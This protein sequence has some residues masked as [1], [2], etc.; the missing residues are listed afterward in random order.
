MLAGHAASLDNTGCNWAYQILPPD[1]PLFPAIPPG[2]PQSEALSGVNV[3]RGNTDYNSPVD[4]RAEMDNMDMSFTVD[5]NLGNYTLSS[6][7]A[8]QEEERLN[9]QDITATAVYFFDVLTQGNAPH[10]GNDQQVETEPSSFTQ[11][12]KIASPAEDPVNFVAGLFYSD[13]TVDAH[14]V[15]DFV[16]NGIDFNRTSETRH[17]AAYGRISRSL[18]HSTK[19]IAGLRYNRD[20]INYTAVQGEILPYIDYYSPP[21]AKNISTTWTGDITIQHDPNEHSMLYATYA[22]GYKPK[23]YNTAETLKPDAPLPA[24]VDR[25][26][27]DHFELGAKTALFDGKIVANTS[28]FDTVYKDYQVLVWTSE[29]R[30]EQGIFVPVLK[31]QNAGEAETRGVELDVS[32]APTYD[33]KLNLN[34]AYI[35]AQF[36]EFENA[37]AYPT[38]TEAEG[39]S[40]V[41]NSAPPAYIQDLSGKSMPD[42]PRFK[43][44]VRLEQR[45]PQYTLP[46]DIIIGGNYVYRSETNLLVNQNPGAKQDA[47]GILDLSVKFVSLTGKSSLT[48]FVNNVFDKFY[49]INAG[50]FWS[51]LWGPGNNVIAGDPARDALRYAG[52]ALNLSF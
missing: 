12:L 35:E 37:P 32:A 13:V 46:F 41:P 47:F 45:I 49:L 50:D 36:N 14:W 7:T 28:V 4:M 29:A 15:R 27:I 22:R 11:E 16:L 2:I 33:T 51:G 26:K 31:M 42:A 9:I 43:A 25:E 30:G 8:Y 5:Y 18:R 38:Q 19:L 24:P 44:A 3:Y 1:I 34:L 17:F 48:L 10:W 39:A 52:V 21:G 20:R 40:L 6:I 23:A